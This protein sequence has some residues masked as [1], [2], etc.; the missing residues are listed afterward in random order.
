MLW[1]ILSDIVNGVLLGQMVTFLSLEKDAV[2]NDWKAPYYIAISREGYWVQSQILHISN[3]FGFFGPG[4]DPS[5]MASDAAIVAQLFAF[6]IFLFLNLFCHIFIQSRR[7]LSE[8]RINFFSS[9][10]V[11]YLLVWGFV[12]GMVWA[13]KVGARC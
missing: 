10:M 11:L 3:Q 1:E 7:G 12:W 2:G 13:Y 9:L 5:K 8:S 6:L 4:D